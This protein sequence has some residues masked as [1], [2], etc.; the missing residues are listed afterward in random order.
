[1]TSVVE[2]LR[3]RH[4]EFLATAL[5]EKEAFRVLFSVGGGFAGLEAAGVSGTLAAHRNAEAYVEAV[6]DLVEKKHPAA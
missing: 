1:L 6:L 3:E 5:L 4:I 2:R